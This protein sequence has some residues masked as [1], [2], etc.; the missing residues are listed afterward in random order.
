[1]MA[2][3]GLGAHQALFPPVLRSADLAGR[4]TAAAAAETGLPQGLPV[5]AGGAT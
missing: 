3:F 4:V 5:V 2:L 1:M